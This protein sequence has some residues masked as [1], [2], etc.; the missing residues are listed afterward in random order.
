[1]TAEDETR[2]QRFFRALPG[3]A[4]WEAAHGPVIPVGEPPREAR[5]PKSE[6]SQEEA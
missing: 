1:M 4:E 5:S 3:M 6:Q 2:F